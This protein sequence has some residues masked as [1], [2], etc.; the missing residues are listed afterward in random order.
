MKKIF[1]FLIFMSCG[2]N[3]M[4][5]QDSYNTF[6]NGKMWTFDSPPLEYFEKT[7]GFKPSS[8]WLEKIRLSALRFGNGCSASFVSEDGLV[9]TN[10]HCARAYGTQVQKKGENFNDNGFVALKLNEER[11]VPGLF[12]DQ[13]VKLE[14]VTTRIKTVLDQTPENKLNKVKDSLFKSITSEYKNKWISDSLTPSVITFYKGAKYSVYGFKRFTDVRLVLLPEEKLG[15]FGGDY[16]NFTYPRYA[17]DFTFFRVYDKNGKP[18]KPTNYY[19]INLEN[20]KENDPV[21]V[22]GNPGTTERLSTGTQLKFAEEIAMPYRLFFIRNRIKSYNVYNETAHNDSISNVIFSLS[23]ANKALTGML[24]ALKNPNLMGRKASFETYLKKYSTDQN[25]AKYKN[26]WTKVDSLKAEIKTIY[27][28]IFGY[29]PSDKNA[30]TAELAKLICDLYAKSLVV[31]DSVAAKN[32]RNT[33]VKFNITNSIDLEK[34]L[35]EN[36]IQDMEMAGLINK[37]SVNTSILTNSAL[38]DSKEIDNLKKHLQDTSYLNKLISTD[39]LMKF[40]YSKVVLFNKTKTKFD[41]LL[42]QENSQN[43]LLAQLQFEAF[44]NMIPPDANFNL[45]IA[46][47]VVKTYEYNGTK[48]PFMTTYYGLYDRFYSFATES[49][50]Q[51]PERWKKPNE[52]ILQSPLNFVSTND[53]IGGN[54]GSP[55]LNKKG[56]VV[57]LIFDGNMESLPGRYIYDDQYNRSVS[58]HIAGIYNAVKYIYKNKRIASEL[59]K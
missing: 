44:G 40:W 30:Q 52:K 50:W 59:I 42:V 41:K 36:Q 54:S 47:G 58:V 14:D 35:F 11:K 22:V 8:D 9:M 23:N 51:L 38:R 18:F 53:I 45:R 29:Q 28:I 16:D 15:F 37:T 49:A 3:L 13:L 31:T 55:I 34:S 7:Y 4:T 1:A 17:L 6:D 21:F 32:L 57:G 56:E 25:L 48:A 46:D 10:H 12:V 20:L 24:D 5:A 33:I 19:K 39:E 43:A 26:I 2:I 27:P